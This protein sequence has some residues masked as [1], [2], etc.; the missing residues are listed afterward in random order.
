MSTDG[1][2][3]DISVYCPDLHTWHHCVLF[4]TI[5]VPRSPQ[6]QL[7]TLQSM[8]VCHT[9]VHAPSCPFFCA[10]L[11]FSLS[12]PVSGSLRKTLVTVGSFGLLMVSH[13]PH[14][15]HTCPGA[16]SHASS[17][18]FNRSSPPLWKASSRE[19]GWRSQLPTKPS[20]VEMNEGSI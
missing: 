17:E 5:P 9:C 2:S 4:Y 12:L 16:A 13:A 10:W 6:T 15:A 7:Y 14:Y 8:P 11:S 20:L 19:T 1:S 18:V 3:V